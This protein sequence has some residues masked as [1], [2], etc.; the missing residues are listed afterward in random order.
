MTAP[1]LRVV[2]SRDEVLEAALRA[3]TLIIGDEMQFAVDFRTK[4]AAAHA[5]LHAC[6]DPEVV[7]RMEREQ[8]LR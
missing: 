7:K 2:H 8:G 5:A 4:C 3:L 6:R 1:K